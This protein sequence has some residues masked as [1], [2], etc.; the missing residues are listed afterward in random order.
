MFKDEMKNQLGLSFEILSGDVPNTQGDEMFDLLW[1][2]WPRWSELY[3]VYSYVPETRVSQTAN[4]WRIGPIWNFSP[5]KNADFQLSYNALFADESLPTRAPNLKLFSQDG[6]FRGHY[7]QAWL[8]YKFSQHMAG[9][10]WSEFVWQG[11][12]YT[13]EQLMTFL[14]AEVTFTF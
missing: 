8:K 3:N 14:R 12:Y 5:V 7:V 2:R 1:G 6:N 10:L 13:S 11:D 4:V 9:H